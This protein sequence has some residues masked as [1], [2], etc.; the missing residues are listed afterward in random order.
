MA[1]AYNIYREDEIKFPC[2]R[3]L[4]TARNYFRRN[5]QGEYNEGYCEMIDDDCLCYFDNLNGQPVQIMVYDDGSIIV[6]VVY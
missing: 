5:Y 6:H 1:K 2:F 4:K 3:S